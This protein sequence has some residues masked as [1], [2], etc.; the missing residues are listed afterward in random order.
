MRA[1]T[2]KKL[3]LATH[4]KGKLAELR[5]MFAPYGIELVSAGE[6]NL[7]EPDETEDTFIG[8]ALIKAKAAVAASG[9]PVLADD[10]GLCVN[11]LN[12]DPGV[13]SANWAG[14]GKDFAPAMERVNRELDGKP[15]RSAYFISVFVLAWPD[16]ETA[17][18][19][20]RVDGDIVWPPRG[21]GGHGYDPVFQAK[22]ETRT[23][24]EMT[25]EEKAQY[26]HRANAFAELVKKHI[27]G[28]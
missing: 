4:N 5:G 10:S 25:L 2:D 8:N 16:G 18:L 21:T 7:P 20:G 9:L 19:E 26:S 13:Y 17:V 24:G 3:V 15:D 23:F 22:G 28:T 11:A 6:L 12:G 14:P 27:A 1:F